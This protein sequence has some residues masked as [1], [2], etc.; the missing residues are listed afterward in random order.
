MN[1]AAISSGAGCESPV[2]LPV[3]VD[4]TV[5]PLDILIPDGFSPNGDNI[6]DTFEI[7]NIRE[8][9]PQFRIEIYNRYGNILFKGNINTPDWDGTAQEGGLKVG[10]GVVPTGV[11]FYIL[12]FNDGVRKPRQGRLY[13]SR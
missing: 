4:T 13:L 9:Y 5:C 11:Y 1:Y 12:E 2:R 7:V 8:L 6:N 3:T 10:D